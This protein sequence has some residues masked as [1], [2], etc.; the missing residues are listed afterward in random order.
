MKRNS[1]LN[2]YINTTHTGVRNGQN[3]KKKC[4]A[5]TLYFFKRVYPRVSE[6]G[7]MKKRGFVNLFL[8]IG[9]KH[10]NFT[11]LNTLRYTLFKKYA[12]WARHFFCVLAISDTRDQ[13]RGKKQK[14][15]TFKDITRIFQT[16]ERPF[17]LLKGIFIKCI[18]TFLK[19][20][21]IARAQ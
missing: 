5:Q 10:F 14:K 8:L 6:N 15:L 13:S 4:L 3:T 18:W 1:T 11:I 20:I 16:S 7:K 12:V 2:I 21:Y 19:H 9:M 17:K